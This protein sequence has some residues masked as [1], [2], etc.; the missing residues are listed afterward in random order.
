MKHLGW[1]V[2]VAA[3]LLVVGFLAGELAKRPASNAAEATHA[4]SPPGDLLSD[5]AKGEESLAARQ[6]P[7]PASGEGELRAAP[8]DSSKEAIFE[9]I[10][11]AST[12][13]DTSA[14][15]LIEPYL[16]HADL[17]VRA[18][19]VEGLVALGESG[20]SSLLRSAASKLADPREAVTYLDAADYLDLP[21]TTMTELTAEMAARMKEMPVPKGARFF[22]KGA[23]ARPMNGEKGVGG[24]AAK[25]KAGFRL[26]Q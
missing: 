5:S 10:H 19:A 14:L 23:K 6:P 17:E 1:M 13:Y 4:N 26:P 21:P 18:A 20:G 9:S 7:E 12:L 8:A 16:S 2:L 25:S 15:P 11:E 24:G 22:P 3:I